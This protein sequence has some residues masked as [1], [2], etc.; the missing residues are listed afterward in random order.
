MGS[1]GQVYGAEDAINLEIGK[2]ENDSGISSLSFLVH[3]KP[4]TIKCA[5]SCRQVTSRLS[6]LVPVALATPP[7]S[8]WGFQKRKSEGEVDCLLYEHLVV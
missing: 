5:A 6:G 7:L 3:E 8:L 4:P 2:G 1:N